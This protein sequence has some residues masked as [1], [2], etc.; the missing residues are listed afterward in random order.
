MAC[1]FAP[2]SQYTETNQRVCHHIMDSA[3]KLFGKS[4]E[5]RAFVTGPAKFV[6]LQPESAAVY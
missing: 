3:E 5:G 4:M 6:H 1:H 2:Q